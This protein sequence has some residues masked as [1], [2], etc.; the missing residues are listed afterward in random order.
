MLKK[1]VEQPDVCLS[2]ANPRQEKGGEGRRRRR[3]HV[4][5]EGGS[6]E[7]RNDSKATKGSKCGRSKGDIS[8]GRTLKDCGGLPGRVGGRLSVGWVPAGGAPDSGCTLPPA[9]RMPPPGSVQTPQELLPHSA[10]REACCRLV[11]RWR[12]TKSR[13]M[14]RRVDIELDAL[15]SCV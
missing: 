6:D 14:S 1:L 4:W 10:G 15:S 9:A 8:S 7:K 2:Q 5:Q 13:C 11:A 3:R 12:S